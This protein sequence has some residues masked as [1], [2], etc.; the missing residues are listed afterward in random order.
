M[1]DDDPHA[2]PSPRSAQTPGAQTPSAQTPGAQTP[3]ARTSSAKPRGPYKR[4][5]TT[6]A[7]I[8]EAATQVFSE[9]GYRAGS[10]REVARRCGIDQSTVTHHFPSKP[11]LL[12]ALMHERDARGDALVAATQTDGPARPV[13]AVLA[14]ARH[15]ESS[16][17]AIALYTVLAAES[18]TPDHPLDDYF[19]DRLR[20]VRT[21]FEG[22]LSQLAEDGALRDGVTPSWA[23]ATLL[24][25]WEGAQ[26][27]WLIDPD[28]VDVPA[29]L[30]GF[31]HLILHDAGQPAPDRKADS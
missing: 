4:S 13:D 23:A 8:L 20:H 2:T 6:R 25:L 28:E 19:R 26:L 11:A 15:N 31:L 10:M 12:L 14:L 1:I 29:A 17:D 7:A 27:H 24:S 3:S 5:A 16:P 18:V 30:E 21:N 22:W 9:Q